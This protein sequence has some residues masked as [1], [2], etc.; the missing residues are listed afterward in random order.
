MLQWVVQRVLRWSRE[1][2]QVHFEDMEVDTE[3][4]P[5]PAGGTTE[6][7]VEMDVEETWRN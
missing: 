7:Q 1:R 5:A 6:G 2:L 3:Q 4:D